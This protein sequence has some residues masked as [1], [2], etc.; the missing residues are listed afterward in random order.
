MS[1]T[2]DGY[3]FN[4]PKSGRPTDA[5]FS[6]SWYPGIQAYW[7]NCT[8]KRSVD[9][10]VG[11]RAVVIHATAGGSSSGAIS[12]M[13]RKIDPASFHWLVP[14]E[15]ESQHGSLVWACAPEA[16]AAWHVRNAAFHPDVNSGEKRV[17]H[18]SLGIEVV[19]T[20]IE[21]PFSNWQVETTARIVRYCWA[22]YPNLVHIVSHAKLDPTRRSDPGSAFPWARFKDLVLTSGN[23]NVPSVAILATPASKIRAATGGDCCN[24]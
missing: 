3:Q 8:T 23:D 21:D 13:K 24:G 6:E 16:S 12:V 18:W 19:N 2:A 1:G 5:T 7:P 10:I 9:P 17:N 14:D 4:L 20:Q 15:D 22:K 11:I